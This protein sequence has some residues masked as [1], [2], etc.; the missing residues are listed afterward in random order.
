MSRLNFL[1]IINI[2]LFPPSGRGSPTLASNLTVLFQIPQY[3]SNHIV[4]NS[5]AGTFY[6]FFCDLTHILASII[7][8]QVSQFLFALWTRPE[9]T[10]DHKR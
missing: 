5:G 10:E 1:G 7:V 9:G 6:F 3:S 8:Q 2:T 4:A